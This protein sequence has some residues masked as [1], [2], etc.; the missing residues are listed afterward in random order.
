MTL[1]A[2]VVIFVAGLNPIRTCRGI[3]DAPAL[4]VAL[5]ASA[6]AVIYAVI[7]FVAATVRDDLDV[8]APNAR[9]AAG[10]VLIVVGLHALIA[11]LPK[12]PTGTDTAYPWL[13]PLLFPVWLRPDLALVAL[14]AHGLP[15][16]ASVALGATIGL[17]VAA[18]WWWLLR[19]RRDT[20]PNI[21]RAW[22]A[23]FGAAAVLAAV[24]LT[25]DGVFGL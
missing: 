15:G 18:L 25:L 10:L 16:I 23:V 24:R 9:I 11:P 19:A 7:A 2:V 17:G 14:A 22:G 12:E 13:T 4:A 5:S 21:E 3:G 20:Q 8:S 1:W 6:A